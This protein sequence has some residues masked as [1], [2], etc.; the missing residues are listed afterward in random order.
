MKTIAFALVIAA[1]VAVAASTP[2]PPQIPSAFTVTITATVEDTTSTVEVF[3]DSLNGRLLTRSTEKLTNGSAVVSVLR[4]MN[5]YDESKLGATEYVYTAAPHASCSISGTGAAAPVTSLF[6]WLADAT[7]AGQEEVTL[8][9]GKQVMTD[10]WTRTI[11]SDVAEGKHFMSLFVMDGDVPVRM[12]TSTGAELL[13]D[14]FAAGVEDESVFAVPASCARSA[15]AAA[16]CPMAAAAAKPSKE[17]SFVR[18]GAVHTAV[19]LMSGNLGI[20]WKCDLC[21]IA[22]ESLISVGCGGG[23]ALCGPFAEV[24]EEMCESGCMAASCSDRVCKMFNFC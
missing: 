21:K 10:M 20:H 11:E 14:D 8:A 23:S 13:F 9:S 15:R 17:L 16:S 4:I 3:T 24:C 18:P 19:S 12:T 5:K 22:A 6:A 7:Y 2:V 1:A